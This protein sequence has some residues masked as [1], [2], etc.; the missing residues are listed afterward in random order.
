MRHETRVLLV[1]AEAGFFGP[2][3]C[4]Q[5]ASKRAKVIGVDNFVAGAGWVRPPIL[6]DVEATA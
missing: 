4:Q 3:F 2:R 5:L 1:V 6:Y